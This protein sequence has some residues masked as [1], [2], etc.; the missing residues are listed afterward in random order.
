MPLD[1][2][3]I[4]F[5]TANGSPASACAVGLVKVVDGEVVARDGWLIR[6]PEGHDE[7]LPFNVQLH[8]VSRERALTADRW[9][10]QLP[11]LLGLVGDDPIVAHNAPFDMGVLAAASIA[12]GCALPDLDYCCSLRVAR[13][14]YDL[15]SYRLPV[16]SE[17]AGF[18]GLTH[19]DPVSDADACAAI[20]IDAAKRMQSPDLVE[21]AHAVGVRMG[22]LV[23]AERA[24]ASK[25][26]AAATFPAPQR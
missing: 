7:F 11:R 25:L 22:R 1:F 17:A 3:A 6:P 4:D 18:V 14:V 5:E 12:T 21:L 2:T 23:L 16:A 24:E 15:P 10:T 26:V 9:E 8:G 20:V 13:R 19:H